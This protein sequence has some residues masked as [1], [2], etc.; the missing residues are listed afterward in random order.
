MTQ[1][2]LFIVKRRQPD[3]MIF[4]KLKTNLISRGLFSQPRSKSYNKYKSGEHEI[5]V[6]V[7][8]C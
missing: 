6:L 1:N 2:V 3:G 8:V 4:S 5:N 7:I